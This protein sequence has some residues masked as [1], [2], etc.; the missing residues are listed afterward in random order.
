MTIEQ[1]L[2]LLEVDGKPT[3][4]SIKKAFRLAAIK[5]HPDKRGSDKQFIQI[6]EAYDILIAL[7][8]EELARYQKQT[9]SSGLY[10]P[11]DDFD[12]NSRVF[13]TPDNPATEGFE[14]KIRAK[15]CPHCNGYGFKTK[16]TDPSKGFIGRETRLCRCQWQ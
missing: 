8:T 15:G 4:S 9:S 13:F 2:D 11:F 16:N 10:D 12:Y 1:C 14:R 3:K 7:S 6:K 5:H